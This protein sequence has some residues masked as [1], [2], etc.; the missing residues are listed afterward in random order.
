MLRQTSRGGIC[1]VGLSIGRPDTLPTR[2]TWNTSTRVRTIVDH[3]VADIDLI[4]HSTNTVQVR[5]A[6]RAWAQPDRCR[7]HAAL[8]QRAM[9]CL[10]RRSGAREAGA[11]M[12]PKD[13]EVRRPCGECFRWISNY[14]SSWD[15]DCWCRVHARLDPWTGN[16]SW[17]SGIARTTDHSCRYSLSIWPG[18]RRRCTAPIPNRQCHVRAGS[19]SRGQAREPGHAT[20]AETPSHAD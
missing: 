7:S 9:N 11:L 16:C 3:K 5:L 13:P 17:S 19:T 18:N 6:E 2:W 15:R 12:D 14:P 8:A 20:A 10:V 4:R 1:L